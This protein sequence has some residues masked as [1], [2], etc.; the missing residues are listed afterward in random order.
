LKEALMQAT[1]LNV[2]GKTAIKPVQ[3][4]VIAQPTYAMLYFAF[5]KDT[6]LVAEDGEIEFVSKVGA[7]PVK[8]KFD[9]KK[10]VVNGK[11]DM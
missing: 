11:L 4:E 2:K 7:S 5:P 6:P 9:L 1:V 10:M 8:T 3:V